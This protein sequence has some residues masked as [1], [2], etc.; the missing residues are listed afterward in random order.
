MRKA[1][2]SARYEGLDLRYDCLKYFISQ[3]GP[4]RL[5]Q[6][7][8]HTIKGKV[9]AII[10]VMIDRTGHPTLSDF[11]AE[12]GITDEWHDNLMYDQVKPNAALIHK[13]IHEY[14]VNPLFIYSNSDQMWC[15]G[16]AL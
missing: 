11:Y 4:K 5:S 8:A 9:C 13:L 7:F 10:N 14:D 6:D 15:G 16:N 1:I 3:R 12:I 2:K